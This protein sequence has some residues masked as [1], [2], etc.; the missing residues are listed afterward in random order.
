MKDAQQS[1]APAH[2]AAS[3]IYSMLPVVIHVA[4]TL[5]AAFRSGIPQESPELNRKQPRRSP[6]SVLSDC[7]VPP[8]CEAGTKLAEKYGCRH[9]CMLAK[10]GFTATSVE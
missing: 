9:A 10:M 1:F 8:G 2:R 5:T 6:S 3:G 4:V 7:T